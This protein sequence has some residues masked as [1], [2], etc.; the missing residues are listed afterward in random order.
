MVRRKF[1]LRVKEGFA[2]RTSDEDGEGPRRGREAN[3]GV[4]VTT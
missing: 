4:T 3:V 2:V 1:D